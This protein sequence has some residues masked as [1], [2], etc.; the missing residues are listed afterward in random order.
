MPGVMST[1]EA[2]GRLVRGAREQ[3]GW[4]TAELSVEM[5]R[6]GNPPH[7]LSRPQIDRI[8]QGN[9]NVQPAEAW[10]L[11]EVLPDLDAEGLLEAV[12]VLSEDSSAEFRE[13]VRQEVQRRRQRW[14]DG[15]RRYL[16]LASVLHPASQ[17]R[18]RAFPQ[19]SLFEPA[20]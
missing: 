15:F 11:L 4:T 12:G 18:S 9:R 14:A 3:R 20:A 1:S 6:M 17:Y 8:E 13:M 2:A 19:H 5:G 10:R 16:T 7:V